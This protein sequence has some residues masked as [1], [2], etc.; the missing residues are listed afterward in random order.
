M[1]AYETTFCPSNGFKHIV[2][3]NIHVKRVQTN[4]T[5]WTD[6]FSQCERLIS[7]INKIG[8][9]SVDGFDTEQNTYTFGIGINFLHTFHCPFPLLFWSSVWNNF[10]NG[11]GNHRYHFAI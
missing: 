4:A 11:G 3:L 8:F 1:K 6:G 10:A 9:E 7:P 5:I 2:F